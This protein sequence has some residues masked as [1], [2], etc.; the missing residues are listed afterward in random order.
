LE[1]SESRITEGED[2]QSYEQ[3][4][5]T[6]VKLTSSNYIEILVSKRRNIIRGYMAQRKFKLNESKQDQLDARDSGLFNQLY[7]TCFGRFYAHHQESRLPFTAYG[8][9]HWLLLVVVLESRE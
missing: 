2:C 1:V 8:F 4:A 7:P 3:V 5:V 6:N 9:R